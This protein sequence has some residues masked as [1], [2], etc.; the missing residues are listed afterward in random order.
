M[1]TKLYRCVTQKDS[2]GH[3]WE[4]T[5]G[6]KTLL[7]AASN[8]M[9]DFGLLPDT[10]MLQDVLPAEVASNLANQ[11][12]AMLR[13]ELD[14]LQEAYGNI[15]EELNQMHRQ[16]VTYYHRYWNLV[17]AANKMIEKLSCL[18]QEP[19]NKQSDFEKEKAAESWKDAWKRQYLGDIEEDE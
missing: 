15:K 4:G 9:L 1:K 8:F 12:D 18:L 14:I 2:N 3:C 19:V 17:S 10:V 7:E 11:G 5:Y 16:E 13:Q 6:C